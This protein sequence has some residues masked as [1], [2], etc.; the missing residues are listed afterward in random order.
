MFLNSDVVTDEDDRPLVHLPPFI[1]SE[2]K[3]IDVERRNSVISIVAY[4]MLIKNGYYSGAIMYRTR[5]AEN[6]WRGERSG[7]SRV[8][9]KDALRSTYRHTVPANSSRLLVNSATKRAKP[10]AIGVMT[11]GPSTWIDIRLLAVQFSPQIYPNV[12]IR[13]ERVQLR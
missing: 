5:G 1:L 6:C 3:N 11:V 13:D 10:T 7:R 12:K 4:C 8:R 9:A 2:K